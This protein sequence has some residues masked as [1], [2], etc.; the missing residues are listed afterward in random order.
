MLHPLFVSADKREKPPVAREGPEWHQCRIDGRVGFTL[1]S[2]T[3]KSSPRRHRL[4]ENSFVLN[5]FTYEGGGLC[6]SAAG[7]VNQRPALF[8]AR[9]AK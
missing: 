9:Q 3:W 6:L 7:L 8:Y 2:E 1:Q 5:V 4:R